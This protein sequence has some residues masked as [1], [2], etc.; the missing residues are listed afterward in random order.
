MAELTANINLTSTLLEKVWTTLID[1]GLA[2]LLRPWQIKRVGKAEGEASAHRILTIAQAERHAEE[3][4]AGRKALLS[5]GTVVDV[6]TLDGEQA[7]LR[8]LEAFQRAVLLKGSFNLINTVRY[9]VDNETHSD[10]HISDDE[11]SHHW[12]AHWQS[13]AETFSEEKFQRLWAA[14]L[15]GEVRQPGAFSILA[16]D[17]LASISS[18]NAWIFQNLCNMSF[19]NGGRSLILLGVPGWHGSSSHYKIRSP[20]TTMGEQLIGYGVTHFHLLSMRTVGFYQV[21]L[22]KIIQNGLFF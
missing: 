11:V 7:T 12:F 14:V 5:D 4:M 10:L 21:Y 2:G 13:H 1:N 6:E 16:M 8:H 3:I 18:E 19:S 17:I 20:S 9:I 15:V 22:M